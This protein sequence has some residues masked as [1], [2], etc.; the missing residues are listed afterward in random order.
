MEKRIKGEILE[1]V[2][3]YFKRGGS[4]QKK[5]KIFVK[6]LFWSGASKWLVVSNEDIGF[7]LPINEAEHSTKLK[8]N[9]ILKQ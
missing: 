8:T 7:I 9:E 6:P 3:K 5:C 4:T 1:K 2:N